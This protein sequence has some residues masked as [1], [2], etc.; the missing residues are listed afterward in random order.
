MNKLT[1]SVDI[2]LVPIGVGTSLSSYIV[3][4]QKIFKKYKLTTQLHAFGTNLEG[5]WDNV[6][7]A[8]KECHEESH[9]MGAPRITSTIKCGTRIDKNQTLQDKIDSVQQQ[10]SE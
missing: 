7:N 1:V 4:C 3:N 9:K 6:F 10:L 8:I 2:C 5:P